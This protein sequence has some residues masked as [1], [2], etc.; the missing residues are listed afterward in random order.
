MPQGVHGGVHLRA[1]LALVPVPAAPSP[2]LRGGPER[3]GVEDGRRGL[4][5][6][7]PRNPQEYAQIVDHLLE[8]ARLEP[9]PR[10]LVD[11][12]PR[13]QVV[14]HAPWRA[15]SHHPPETIEHFAQIVVSLEG[16]LPDER[17]VWGDKRP[18]FVGNVARVR[19]SSS[20]TKMVPFPSQSS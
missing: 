12:L 11:G 9:P 17:E 19:F 15:S 6:S 2:A 20:H 16:V 18:L 7:A 5:R 13:R 14:G 3:A 1:L 8:D 4:R 10:L